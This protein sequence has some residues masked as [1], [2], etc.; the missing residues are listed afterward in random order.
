MSDVTVSLKDATSPQ[1]AT[2]GQVVRRTDLDASTVRYIDLSAW[3]G[4]II[5]IVASVDIRY[6][7]TESASPTP[8]P[9]AAAE[10]ADASV[11]GSMNHAVMDFLGAG[12]SRPEIVDAAH[13]FLA[14]LT[15]GDASGDL[16]VRP[17]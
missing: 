15:A 6:V 12:E 3:I 17:W 4:K 10:Q 9:T 14:V 7:W 8:A 5:K 1:P 16:Y 2:R 11:G 13:P